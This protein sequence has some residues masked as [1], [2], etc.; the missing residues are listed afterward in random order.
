MSCIILFS[1]SLFDGVYF[2]IEL[3]ITFK[4]VMT[5]VLI[6]KSYIWFF[7]ESTCLISN[8]GFLCH[9]QFFMFISLV[10][11][12]MLLLKLLCIES[13]FNW[14]WWPILIVYGYFFDCELSF[15]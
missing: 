11:I 3:P 5:I 12:S 7:L 15:S 14:V 10:I 13:I 4:I 2:A 9:F 1:K 6:S 8:N